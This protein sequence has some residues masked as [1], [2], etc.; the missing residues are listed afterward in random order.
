M[1]GKSFETR[2]YGTATISETPYTT[3]GRKCIVLKTKMG[4]ITLTTNIPQIRLEEGEFCIKTWSENMEVAKDA[5]KSGLF[6]DT[7]KKVHSGHVLVPIW[8]YAVPVSISDPKTTS[9]QNDLYNKNSGD[10]NHF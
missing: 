9:N 7:N 2:D 10:E 8:K 3:N 1:I 5:L 4:R 6:I